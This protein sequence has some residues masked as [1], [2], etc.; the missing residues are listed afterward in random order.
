MQ[1]A[2]VRRDLQSAMCAM[3][4]MQCAGVRRDL[5]SAMCAM[6]EM[7]YAGV[8]P[9]NAVPSSRKTYPCQNLQ[10]IDYAKDHG[11]S[12]ADRERSRL[13][14]EALS[15][16]LLYRTSIYPPLVIQQTS[17][18]QSISFH[19][20][21]NISRST[22][23]TAAVILLRRLA[24]SGGTKTVSFTNLQKKKKVARD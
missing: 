2:G 14:R 9:W 20:R 8:R 4:Q 7:Q 23:A 13:S 12:Y 15:L 5:Q 24:G 10:Q 19:T 6:S 17:M 16:S 21:V 11:N 3:S 18:R 1:C 22:R